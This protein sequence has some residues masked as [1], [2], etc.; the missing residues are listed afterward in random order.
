MTARETVL[1]VNAAYIRSAAQSDEARTEPPF[2]LQG[3][4]RSMNKIAARDLG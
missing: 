2:R 4:Y 1:A 3:S